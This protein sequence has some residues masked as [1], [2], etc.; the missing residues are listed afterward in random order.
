MAVIKYEND[1]KLNSNCKLSSQIEDKN[2]MDQLRKLSQYFSGMIDT[3]PAKVYY[4]KNEDVFEDIEVNKRAIFEDS[5]LSKKQKTNGLNWIQIPKR[6]FPILQ[7]L[8]A[9]KKRMMVK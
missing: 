8:S 3:I 5:N 9:T 7:L 2:T 6:K 4:T 1:L